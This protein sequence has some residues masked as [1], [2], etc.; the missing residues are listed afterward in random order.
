[1]L[2]VLLHLVERDLLYIA[3]KGSFKCLPHTAMVRLSG[4]TGELT[5][6]VVLCRASGLAYTPESCRGYLEAV[7]CFTPFC[8]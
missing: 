3:G 8:V 6:F 2:Q 4:T 7:C 5:V 1:M